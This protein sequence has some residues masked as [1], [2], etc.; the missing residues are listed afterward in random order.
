[1]RTAK[2]PTQRTDGS[3]TFVQEEDSVPTYHYIQYAMMARVVMTFDPTYSV[4]AKQDISWKTEYY[5]I[6]FYIGRL[7]ALLERG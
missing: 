3:I 2:N 7:V 4:V 6:G 5:T 1:M